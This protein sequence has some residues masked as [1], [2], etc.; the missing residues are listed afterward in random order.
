MGLAD[1]SINILVGTHAIFQEKVQYKNLALAVIDEQHK[2]GVSQRLMLTQ[3][4]EK[5]PHLLAMTATPIPRT[6]TLSQFG[7]MDVSRI[8]ELPPGRQAIETRVISE[9]RQ[10]E[11][12]RWIV[13]AFICWWASLLGLPLGGR[14]RKKRSGCCGRTC[15]D[16]QATVWGS[17]WAGTWPDERPRKRRSDGAVPARRSQIAGRDYS[18]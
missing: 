6:L 9:S 10:P 13:A 2:F 15:S 5:T 3:K 4:A 17:G 12:G 1:G 18:Y 8:D 7:E 14:K 11:V 16:A